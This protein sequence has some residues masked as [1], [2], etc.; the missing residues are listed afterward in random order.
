MSVIDTVVK[1]LR[2]DTNPETK[3]FL[4]TNEHYRSPENLK[5]I[6]CLEDQDPAMV[7]KAIQC[8]FH[9]FP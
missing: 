8:S 5:K 4:G 6:A 1:T 9:N 7:W 2:T 3:G